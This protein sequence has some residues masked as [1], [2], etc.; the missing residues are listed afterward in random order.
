MLRKPL[1]GAL[2]VILAI[3]GI[4]IVN[5]ARQTDPLAQHTLAVA[6]PA[7]LGA[8]VASRP[9]A[10]GGGLVRTE[11]LI[12]GPVEATYTVEVLGSYDIFLAGRT[13]PF[14]L[15][16]RYGVDVAGPNS[17]QELPLSVPA[18]RAIRVTTRYGI[19]PGRTSRLRDANGQIGA[20]TLAG[21]A[22]RGASRTGLSSLI[23]PTGSL[24][25]V[26]MGKRPNAGKI[27]ATLNFSSAAARNALTVKPALNQVFFI[28]TGVAGKKQ[29]H[30]IVPRGATRLFLAALAHQGASH[31]NGGLILAF[32]TGISPARSPYQPLPTVTRTPVPPTV[33]S[34]ATA[35]ATATAIIPPSA[36]GVPTDTPTAT[37]VLP[38]E[39]VFPTDT[40]TN[41]PPPSST[42][43]PSATVTQTPT[44]TP[45]PTP[46]P[47]L[48]ATWTA[49]VTSTP[50]LTSTA[51][52]TPTWTPFS[53]P[54][55]NGGP[56]ATV[57][58]I[59]P[60]F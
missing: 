39:T 31:R 60:Q 44:W 22:E 5:A 45:T 56:T 37:S 14:S 8:L 4:Q 33:T 13:Y 17:P 58:P 48:T 25:G 34:T 24:V 27:P 23:A 38:F 57:T 54:N 51:T 41:T 7:S 12:S 32:V 16:G 29:K 10:A 6:Q 19:A 47:T 11:P 46:T 55:P 28:G 52:P 26:F 18:G 50:T 42:P 2:V 59:P 49:T 15:A 3:S 53:F 21:S 9:F 20:I 36:T 35:T 43:V 30:F 1:T 40:P